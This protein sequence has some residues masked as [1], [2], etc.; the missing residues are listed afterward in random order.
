MPRKDPFGIGSINLDLGLGPKKKQRDSRR[1]FTR[2]QK[3]EIWAQQGG[4]CARCHKP[5]DP[6]TVEYDHG[7]AWSDGGSTLIKNGRALCPECH[8]LKTHK[9]RLEKVEKME[10]PK[11]KNPYDISIPKIKIPKL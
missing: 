3:N 10:K 7:K 9:E 8:R 11:R 4:K 1:I 6:R 5:L 2:T